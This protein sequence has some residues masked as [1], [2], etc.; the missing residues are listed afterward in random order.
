MH[1][2][3]WLPKPMQGHA[4]VQQQTRTSG[5]PCHAFITLALT[6][7]LGLHGT[8]AQIPSGTCNL[9]LR[10]PLTHC[11][12]NSSNIKQYDN[13]CFANMSL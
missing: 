6:P 13:H 2:R 11:S 7:L 10:H 5:S 8:V 3:L 9:N 12:T 4:G 1:V